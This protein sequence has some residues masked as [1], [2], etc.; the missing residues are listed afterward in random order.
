MDILISNVEKL[1]KKQGITINVSDDAKDLV[2][3]SGVNEEYGARPLKRAIQT[4][5]EDEIAQAIL[6][7]KIKDK[8]E[9]TVKDEKIVIQ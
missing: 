8:A 4:M 7:E 9:V 6:D 1:M 5:I 3:R 2:S